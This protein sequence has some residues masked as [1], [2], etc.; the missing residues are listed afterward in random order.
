M[1][2]SFY[3]LGFVEGGQKISFRVRL[4]DAQHVLYRLQVLACAGI[5]RDDVFGLRAFLRS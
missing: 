4:E 2:V 1:L 5:R 3:L